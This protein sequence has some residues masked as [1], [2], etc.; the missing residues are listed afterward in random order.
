MIAGFV[1]GLGTS[2][3]FNTGS[4]DC[5]NKFV[6]SERMS[7][8]GMALTF[9]DVDRTKCLMVIVGNPAVSRVSFIHPPD[10]MARLGAIVEC[11]GRLAFVNPRRIES[12]KT[13]GRRVF[14]RSDTDVYFLLAFLHE[15]QQR[16]ALDHERTGTHMTGFE[17]LA[18]VVREWAPERQAEVIAISADSLRE[19]V[20]AYLAADGPDS[21]EPIW[22]MAHFNGIVVRVEVVKTAH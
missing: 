13:A 11:G 8:A 16:D 6:V 15:I 1:R 18:D 9:P 2:K 22:G 7:G 10:P 21:I 14:I 19:L 3:C 4:L 5:N 12:D 17:P 20:T